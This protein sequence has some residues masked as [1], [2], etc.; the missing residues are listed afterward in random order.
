MNTTQV[1][2]VQVIL[3]CTR[4]ALISFNA[5]Y[6]SS[7]ALWFQ[8]FSNVKPILI[9]YATHNISQGIHDPSSDTKLFYKHRDTI[10]DKLRTEAAAEW[11]MW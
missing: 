1:W 11:L 7:F 8:Y 10:I 5:F 2:S 4:K 6:I 3:S 9:V